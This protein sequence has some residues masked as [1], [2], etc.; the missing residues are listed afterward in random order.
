MRRSHASTP[1]DIKLVA[2]RGRDTTRHG[3]GSVGTELFLYFDSSTARPVL[4]RPR[5]LS[6]ADCPISRASL[7]AGQ[8]ESSICTTRT[9]VLSGRIDCRGLCI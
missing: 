2:E 7:S 1:A 5:E 3:G 4:Y 8:K 9:G 6:Y